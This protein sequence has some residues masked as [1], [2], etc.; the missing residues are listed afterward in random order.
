MPANINALVMGLD[1]SGASIVPR[2]VNVEDGNLNINVTVA[3]LPV[4]APIVGQ[5]VIGVTGTA[6][7]FSVA[8]VT[9]P[10]GRIFVS[11]PAGNAA[12]VAVGGQGVTNVVDGTGNGVILAGGDQ[13]WVFAPELSMVAV[14][15][16]A[17]DIISFSAM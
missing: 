13:A 2:P 12:P 5:V 8:A 16:T 7:P 4:N 9:L 10:Q 17:D 14:N 15:G 1:S 3:T 6:E 11:A